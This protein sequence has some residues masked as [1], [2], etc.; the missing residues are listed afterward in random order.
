MLS[1]S[2]RVEKRVFTSKGPSDTVDIGEMIGKE[3]R[4]G[5][6]YILYGE[7]GAGKTQLVKGI[8]RGLG[9]QDWEYVLS[10]SY[11]LMNVYEGRNALCHV[12]LYRLDEDETAMLDL[13]EYRAGSILAVEWPERSSE[14]PDDAICVTIDV[15]ADEERRITVV[16]P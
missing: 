11:T 6:I 10:P 2:L 16:K 15:L 13:D 1:G 12:D 8:A 9:V 3:S 4:V 7:L 14:W 5:E